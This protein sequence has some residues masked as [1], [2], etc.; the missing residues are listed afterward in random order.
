MVRHLG[1]W[2]TLQEL[3]LLGGLEPRPGL[4]ASY[5]FAVSTQALPLPCQSF[6]LALES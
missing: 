3:I 4:A 6:V 1:V 2:Q 5:R